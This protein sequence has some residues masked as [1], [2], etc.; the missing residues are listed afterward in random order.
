MGFS[1]PAQLASLLSC[2]PGDFLTLTQLPVPEK[3]GSAS[4]EAKER[5]MPADM[6]LSQKSQRLNPQEQ[7]GSSEVSSSCLESSSLRLE[8]RQGK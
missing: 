4:K 5:N 8:D 1:A 7:D 3:I 2:L 6:N